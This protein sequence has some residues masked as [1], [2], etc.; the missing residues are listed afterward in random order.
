MF[1]VVQKCMDAPLGMNLDLQELM[2][3]TGEDGVDPTRA[4]VMWGGDDQ[5]DWHARKPLTG[6][7]HVAPPKRM[8]ASG[9]P[10]ASKSG[11]GEREKRVQAPEIKM[12][13]AANA[14]SA[15]TTTQDDDEKVVRTIKG[16]LNKLTPDKFDRLAKQALDAGINSAPLLQR[17]I[18][19]VFE[20][21]VAE[22]TF[23]P[24]YAKLCKRLSDS[25]PD[26][27]SEE[28]DNRPITFRRVLLNTCQDEFEGTALEKDKAD[29]I[30]AAR[31]REMAERAVKQRT[32]GNIRLIGELFKEKM[33]PEQ[34]IQ[35]CITELVGGGGSLS[36]EN[37]EALC[38]LMSVT[39]KLLDSSSTARPMVDS[40]MSRLQKISGTSTLPSRIRFMIKVSFFSY[41]RKSMSVAK[42]KNNHQSFTS[43]ERNVMAES[44]GLSNIA[45]LRIRAYALRGC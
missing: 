14:W 12:H 17:C 38:Q 34:I 18:S 37:I 33:V 3:G 30:N 23:C 41:S 28:G 7:E 21:A 36:E 4:G 43:A 22:P 29:S 45:R 5:R 35:V 16:I 8:E 9:E 10:K 13:K 32:L 44:K 40:C 27:P 20:K 39:G 42:K 2:E 11:D 24:L 6:D 26:F 15:G 19:L 25:L 31:E 1:A